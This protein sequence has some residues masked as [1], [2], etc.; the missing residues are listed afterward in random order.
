[1]PKI[2][3]VDNVK[4]LHH[5]EID[6]DSKI[7]NFSI[8]FVNKEPKDTKVDGSGKITEDLF[9][10][11]SKL[12]IDFI[13]LIDKINKISV[14]KDSD[15]RIWKT[16]NTLSFRGKIDFKIHKNLLYTNWLASL[17]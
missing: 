3:T 12:K 8:E 5:Y 17:I 16:Y 15:G 1:L 2:E 10:E 6:T 11:I 13:D 4:E 7:E 9:I 14:Y